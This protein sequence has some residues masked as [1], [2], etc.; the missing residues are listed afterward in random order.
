[1]DHQFFS[2]LLLYNDC[3][4]HMDLLSE[5][6][7]TVFMLVHINSS[8]NKIERAQVFSYANAFHSLAF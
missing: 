6:L 5:L 8:P 1:M 4:G 2:V 7:C 3:P